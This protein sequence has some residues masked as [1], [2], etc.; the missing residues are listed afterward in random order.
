MITVKLYGNLKQLLQKDSIV[1]DLDGKTIRDLIE[2][3]ANHTNDKFDGKNIIIAVNGTDSN[4]LDGMS[5]ILQADDTA[6][7]IPII[8]GGSNLS[9]TILNH[10]VRL[11]PISKNH[12]LDADFITNIRRQYPRLVI[13]G[14]SAQY[15]L[16]FTHMKKIITISLHM[17]KNK[18]LLSKK[19]ETDILMRF[20]LNNQITQSLKL[21]GLSSEFDFI[22]II[23]GNKIDISRLNR[24][25]KNYITSTPKFSTITTMKHK[26]AISKKH[27]DAIQSTNPVEDILVEKASILL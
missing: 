14:I 4:A 7:I 13:Q 5:T 11:F 19:L 21:A 18:A 15:I 25:I 10:N 9:L 3:L 24:S 20:A 6:S 1:V 8:H 12:K 2:Y 23:V 22:L 26:F 16:G 17:K 27:I